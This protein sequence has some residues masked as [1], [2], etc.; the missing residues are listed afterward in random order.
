MA[1]FL[2]RL[3]KT[4]PIKVVLLYNVRYLA[5][6]DWAEVSQKL[7]VVYLVIFRE[8]LILTPEDFEFIA[9]RH[10]NFGRFK[11]D[12]IIVANLPTKRCFIEPGF[13]TE[14]QI[15]VC[16]TLRMD[17]LIGQI[18]EG[19][20]KSE[21]LLVTMFWWNIH[22]YETKEF[23]ELTMGALEVF[24]ELAREMPKVKFV[25]KPKPTD[26]Q[27]TEYIQEK[28][29]K[30]KG[31]L[32]LQPKEA[33][34]QLI[35]ENVLTKLYPEWR[36]V[37]NITI[38]PWADV[39]DLILQSSVVCAF[40]STTLFE[41]GLAGKPVVI[42]YFDN[43]RMT[44]EGKLYKCRDFLD[45]FDVAKNKTEF[46]DMIEWRLSDGSINPIVQDRRRDYFSS[47]VS[48]LSGTSVEKTKNLIIDLVVQKEKSSL[49]SV[50]RPKL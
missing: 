45:V 7:G 44:T 19:Y 10:R 38:E 18:R 15:T 46:K 3:Y 29:R 5:D 16:G 28:V 14:D 40:D 23:S 41:S 42:P 47:Y 1:G 21:A 36:N 49:R 43:F 6:L 22:R 12:H 27:L 24:T 32:T 50:G 17:A 11:G 39:H 8:G 35:L 34:R 4:L 25:I 26:I 30:Y 9:R 13:A 2:G 48:D 31:P 33:N 20:V 37:G